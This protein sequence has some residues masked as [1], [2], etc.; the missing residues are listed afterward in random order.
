MEHH[1]LTLN[2]VSKRICVS[3]LGIYIVSPT[4]DMSK[5]RINMSNNVLRI[6]MTGT[7]S[8]SQVSKDEA[9]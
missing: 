2:L 4:L 5:I 9:I 7:G 1:L 8:C 3:N 6:A